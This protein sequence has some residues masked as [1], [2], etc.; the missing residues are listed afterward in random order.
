MKL[1]ILAFAA[2]PDDVELGASG[3]LI[4]HIDNGLKVGIVDLTRGELGTRGTADLRDEEAKRSSEIMG[5]AVRENLGFRD[6]FFQNDEEHQ[7]RI[8]E[9]IRKYRPRIV[10]ANAVSDRHP[11]H[12]KGADVVRTA[13]FL[14][15]LPKVKTEFQGKEQAAHRP[16][17]VLH[18]IQFNSLTPDIIIPFGEEV[19]ERKMKVVEAFSSQFY[20]PNSDEPET[21]I[22]SKNF[23]YSVRYRS[24]DMGRMVGAPFG[25]GFTSEHLLKVEALDHLV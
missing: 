17:L 9:M 2:H 11:D 15:G 25:E 8:V 24:A 7:L 19:M 12:G 14:S 4:K 3:T 23:L 18:Y 6:G 16:E 10:L 21:V 13:G 20:D 1:D 5:L 22:S